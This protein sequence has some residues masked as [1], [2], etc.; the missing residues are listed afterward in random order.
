MSCEHNM[1]EVKCSQ[2]GTVDRYCANYCGF[3]SG[4]AHAMPDVTVTI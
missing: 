1:V 2:C 4:H 3:G